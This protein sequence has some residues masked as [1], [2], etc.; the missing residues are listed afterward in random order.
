LNRGP[1]PPWIRF[2]R[3]GPN[4]GSPKHWDFAQWKQRGIIR[5]GTRCT[6][7]KANPTEAKTEHAQTLM[8]AAA[9]RGPFTNP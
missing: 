1:Y 7:W 2:A 4:R 8:T 9:V 5:G 6:P 3:Q